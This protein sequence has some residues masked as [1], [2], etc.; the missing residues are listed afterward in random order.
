MQI[1]PDDRLL[2]RMPLR[3]LDAEA[4]RDAMLAISGDSSTGRSAGRTCR[5]CAMERA[6]LSSGQNVE[7]RNRRSLY[8]Q[9][10]RTQT[11][12]LLGVFDSPSIVFNCVK[13][14]V[15][16]MPLQSLSLLNS[17]FATEQGRLFAARL[18]AEAGPDAADRIE[19]AFLLAT[20]R[21]PTDA[22][23]Q[24][25]LEFLDSAEPGV[26]RPGRTAASVPGPIS[27][28]CCWPAARSHTWSRTSR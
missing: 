12:S 10:R 4:L 8:L 24:A 28:R 18:E 5:L 19:R 9:Q 26:R 25:A 11:L 7:G 14:P 22:E 17:E 16:T 23:C 15:S 27:A 20:A 2:W 1:D 3:R 13:R 21:P 6:R